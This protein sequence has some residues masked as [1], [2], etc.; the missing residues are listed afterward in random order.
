[1][2]ESSRSLQEIADK[3]LV[4]LRVREREPKM[5]EQELWTKIECD[6]NRRK[7]RILINHSIYYVA[8]ASVLLTLVVYG[9]R[10][11]QEKKEYTLD[12]FVSKLKEPALNQEDVC[13]YLNEEKPVFVPDSNAQISYSSKGEIRINK[14]SHI[15]EEIKDEQPIYDQIVVPKGKQTLLTLSDGTTVYLNAG[16]R[17]VY[18]RVFRP[19]CREIYVEGEICLHVQ[20]NEDVPFIVK[21]SGFNVEVLGTIFNVKAYKD[22]ETGEVVLVSG[23]INLCDKDNRKVELKPDQ[24][25]TVNSGVLGEIKPV[26]ASNY[27]IWTTGTL[28][29]DNEP[30]EVVVK[31]LTRFYGASITV[32]PEAGSLII[33]GRADLQLTLEDLLF[34]ISETAPIHCDFRE[35]TYNITKKE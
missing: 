12:Q 31:K 10:Y 27:V 19:D 7:R 32:T 2:G 8:A 6:I 24:L 21:T 16:T 14:K 1:M 23:S 4:Y 5:K 3:L 35:N 33:N 28:I 18:P 15:M 13:L 17:V 9:N 11:F 22:D 34:M 29:I 26:N 30:L 25:A 20:K